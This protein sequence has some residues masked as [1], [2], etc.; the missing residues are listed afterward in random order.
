M[1]KNLFYLTIVAIFTCFLL[2][3]LFDPAL[4]IETASEALLLFREKLFPSLF[5]FLVLGECLIILGI[6][7][8]L[9]YL[10]GK[11]FQ[12]L[13]HLNGKSAF[14]VLMSMLSGFP[15]GPKY[16]KSLYEEGALSKEEGEKALYIVHFSNPLFILGTVFLVLQQRKVT[17]FVL[18]SHILSNFLVAFLNR[19]RKKVEQEK[20]ILLPRFIS[21]KANELSSFGIRFLE[22][23]QSA[24]YTMLFM[25]GSITFFM[26]ASKMFTSSIENPI[27]KS[28]I[29]GILDLT[30]GIFSLQT[31]DLSLF[32]K[33]LFATIF[34]T[35]GSFS[36][37]L[38]VLNVLKGSD[39]SYRPFLKGRMEATVFSILLYLLLFYFV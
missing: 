27:L 37:H 6:P 23:I 1:K 10:L 34:L 30:S 36:V 35:F 18:I 20:R 3:M 25:L 15:S 33:G 2:W 22:A 9:S 28:V 32:L 11:P 39:L 13:F 24:I 7:T 21:S 16:T 26:L 19:G 31:K 14:L 17:Y 12:S 38:Q 5:P 8:Y 4:T 29:T